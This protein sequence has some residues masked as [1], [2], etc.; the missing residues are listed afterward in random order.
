VDLSGWGSLAGLDLHE[1]DLSRATIGGVNLDGANLN[2]ANLSE[3]KI[4]MVNLSGASLY[5]ANLSGARILRTILADADL[6]DAKGLESCVHAG[7]SS[8]GIDTIFKSGCTIPE[9]FLRGCGVPEQF[10]TCARSLVGQPIEFY[11]CFVSHSSHDQA[12][13]ERLY[14]DLCANNL[15]CWY[16][17]EDFEDRRSIPGADRGIHSAL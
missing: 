5:G 17:P 6:T 12:F 15:R 3:T 7:P 13:V 4:I 16:A 2:M 1:A 10:I 9:T 11:S 8:V 14:A